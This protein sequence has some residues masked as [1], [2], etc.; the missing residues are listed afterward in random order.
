MLEWKF[1]SANGGLT[2]KTTSR[3]EQLKL[4]IT[5]FLFNR[6]ADVIREEIYQ[7]LCLYVL[8]QTN[9]PLSAE[10]IVQEIARLL[11]V[12]NENITDSL[13]TIIY[14]ELN[15]LKRNG[16]IE[17]SDDGCFLDQETK[18]THQLP[19]DLGEE[20]LNSTIQKEINS[21]ALAQKPDLTRAELKTLLD[22]E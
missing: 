10:R 18:E 13:K 9:T 14:D 5:A 12:S 7:A 15:T 2:M 3:Q 21:I 17:C 4:K 6:R 1:T 11:T 22:L 20:R 19:D 8:A 16:E